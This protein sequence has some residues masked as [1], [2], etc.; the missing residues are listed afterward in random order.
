MI[1]LGAGKRGF[2]QL[3]WDHEGR[4]E[5]SHIYI[6]H[7]NLIRFIQFQYVEENGVLSK[8]S[9]M[10]VRN[11]FSSRFNAVSLSLLTPYILYLDLNFDQSFLFLKFC[12]L[13][14]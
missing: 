1:K 7:D 5:I 2:S 3:D 14:L 13:T 6:S 11:S 8:L 12:L 4:T 10:P 9:P